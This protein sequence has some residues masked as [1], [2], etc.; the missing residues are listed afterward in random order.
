MS[1]LEK[2][3]EDFVWGRVDEEEYLKKV[4][5]E[6]S[7]DSDLFISK[8]KAIQGDLNVQLRKGVSLTCHVFKLSFQVEE[9]HSRLLEQVNSI[10]TLDALQSEF[11]NEMRN[12][13]GT[14]L[15]DDVCNVLNLEKAEKLGKIYQSSFEQLKADS[16]ALQELIYLNR[17][18]NDGIR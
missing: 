5:E 12:V 1:L 18:L 3:I 15:H 4:V 17:M 7:I 10:E 9:N 14:C 13:Y 6:G 16:L 11:D 2:S 8:V